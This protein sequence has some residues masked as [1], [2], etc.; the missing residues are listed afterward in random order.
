MPVGVPPGP[1]TV[2][3]KVSASPKV[4]GLAGVSVMTVALAA[5]LTIWV[6]V[7]ALLRVKFASPL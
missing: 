1:L 7:V 3:V 5:A 4:E 2:A 6:K